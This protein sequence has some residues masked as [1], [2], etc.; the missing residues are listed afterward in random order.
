MQ[1]PTMS[2]RATFP[3]A[4]GLSPFGSF[5]PQ[6]PQ[7]LGPSPMTRGFPSGP[8]FDTGF[9]RGLGPAAPI[10]P[11]KMGGLT[12]SMTSPVIAPGSAAGT[13][14][15]PRRMSSA[16]DPGPIG[17]PVGP[18]G[19]IGPIAPIARPTANGDASGSG[20]GG[21][22]SSNSG[23]ASPIRRNESP[24]GVLGSSALAADDDEVVTAPSRRNMPPAPV[25]VASGASWHSPRNSI[26]VPPSPWGATPPSQGFSP[27]RG[28]MGAGAA[29]GGLG[30]GTGG[31]WSQPFPAGPAS[32]NPLGV[33]AA[34]GAGAGLGD[35]HPHQ[36]PGSQFFG[37]PPFM[38]PNQS[39]VTPPPHASGN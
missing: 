35:W 24:K 38:H 2:P 32:A 4:H 36:H 23:N 34:N 22:S 39:T 33:G 14:Q 25:G 29:V 26:A 31:L 3:P 27:S 10:G 20:T 21:H 11:P 6:I 13:I 8:P 9:P 1:Q 16:A 7:A 30:M 18:I 12:A 15:P 17:R 19:P 28:G 5:V 37:G